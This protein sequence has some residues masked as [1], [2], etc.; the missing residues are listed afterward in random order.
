MELQQAQITLDEHVRRR[1]AAVSLADTLRRRIALGVVAPGE[2]LASEREL[3]NTFGVGR[4]T[5]R[6]AIRLL[7]EEGLLGTS[8]GRSG[9]TI[10]LDDAERRPSAR[11]IT[12]DLLREV[13]DNFDLRD[14][15]ER[16]A[17]RL[18]A[19]RAGELERWAIR[20]LAEVTVDSLM[21]FRA[22][23]SRF[24]LAIADAGGNRQL[25]EIIRD[26][27]ADFFRWADAA[28]E[29]IEW[30]SLTPEDRAFNVKHRPIAEAILE[31]DAD[32]A[33]AAMHAHLKAGAV[34]FFEVVDRALSL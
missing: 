16:S 24:H 28:W 12:E 9:G 30:R 2:R 19:G 20:G 15:L 18:A 29:R 32:R 27:R 17:A 1:P 31:G 13:R 33:D 8:R 3:A 10:V 26:A 11:P 23:D 14:A 21:G 6:A 25:S 7:A 22:A 4:M 5:V 34:Q